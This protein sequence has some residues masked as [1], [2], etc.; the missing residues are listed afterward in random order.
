MQVRSMSADSQP[1]LAASTRLALGTVQMGLEYGVANT[2]GRMNLAE[3]GRVLSQAR[4]EGMDMLDTAIAYGESEER[5][6]EIG[7]AGWNIV[8][9][10]PSLP[11]GDED[12]REW[13]ADQVR[14]SL[15]RLRV[16]QLGGLLLHRPT[17]LLESHGQ[18]LWEALEEMR[19]EGLVRKIGISIYDPAELDAL[20]PRYAMQLVQAPFNL[21]DRRLVTSGWAY[22]LADQGI[23]IHT[24]S[25]FL[26]GL[27]LMKERPA[28]FALWAPLLAR[29]DAWRA[30]NGEDGVAACLQFALSYSQISKVVVGVDSAAQL[31]GILAAAGCAHGRWPDDFRSDDSILMNP[32]QWPR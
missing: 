2:H 28:R 27:L 15:G 19:T 22:Q 30:A 26:Q 12:V 29:W 10:L 20:L 17:D 8:S 14:A 13:V 5:L 4:A 6:G 21:L 23:E 9:K 32:S 11:K 24:R 25:V 3:A 18:A 16:A 1:K 7:V 31:R